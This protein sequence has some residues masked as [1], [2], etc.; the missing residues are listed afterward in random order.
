MSPA[1]GERTTAT[2]SWAR[3]FSALGSSSELLESRWG[4]KKRKPH[5]SGPGTLRPQQKPR[6]TDNAV[7]SENPIV[8]PGIKASWV[9]GSCPRA[10]EVPEAQVVEWGPLS[11]HGQALTRKTTPSAG[12]TVTAPT[13]S[14]FLFHGTSWAGSSGGCRAQSLEGPSHQT[15]ILRALWGSSS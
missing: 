11:Q 13:D 14:M 7:S 6:G 1:S 3:V 2:A 10:L 8:T 15:G 4:I 12:T 9:W 5:K